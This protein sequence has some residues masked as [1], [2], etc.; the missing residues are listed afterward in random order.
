MDM[1]LLDWTRMGQFYC[2]AGV[3]LQEGKTRVVRPL[4]ARNRE[5]PERKLGWYS[6]RMDGHCRWEVFEL[7]GPEPADPQPPHLEDVWVQALRPRRCL[8]DPGQR[9]AILEATLPA[10]GQPLFGTP[11]NHT[12]TATF[13][14]PGA[15]TRSLVSVIVP[16]RDVSFSA[17]WR[18]GAG[19]SDYRVRL[20]VPGLG[21]RILP[22]KDHFLL[23]Q[24]E[25][26]SGNFDTQVRTLTRAVQQ[27]GE[28]VVVRLGLSRP[29]AG[30]P[31]GAPGVCWLMADGFFSPTN[32]EP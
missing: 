20:P 12:H 19:E 16:A 24:A 21:K 25:L 9:R 30:T 15:G 3:I 29:F 6:A 10:N 27:M 22:L 13:L 31:G 17:S 26:A 28:Q 7:V 2:L 4:P 32:P 1:V 5:G 8:A 14:R 11:L 23:R 18:E